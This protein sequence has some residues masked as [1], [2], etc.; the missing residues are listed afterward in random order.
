VFVMK[1]CSEA[2]GA[3]AQNTHPMLARVRGRFCSTNSS[4]AANVQEVER[5]PRIQP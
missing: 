4:T 1:I 5:H 2:R 3:Y